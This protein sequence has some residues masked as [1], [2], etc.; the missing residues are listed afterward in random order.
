MASSKDKKD[1]EKLVAAKVSAEINSVENSL[2]K[3]LRDCFIQLE[4]W[5]YANVV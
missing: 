5:T 4:K 1:I 2:G 3:S